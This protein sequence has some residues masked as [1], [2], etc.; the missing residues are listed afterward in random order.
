MS[1]EA[2]T[3]EVLLQFIFKLGL[4]FLKL[5]GAVVELALALEIPPLV[6][7]LDL[8]LV[9]CEEVDTVAFQTLSV[10]G[11]G[12]QVK[13]HHVLGCHELAQNLLAQVRQSPNHKVIGVEEQAEEESQ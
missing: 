4:N 8:C 13:V 2:D 7:F 9:N 5:A 3:D 1:L 12:N 6:A 10:V 11:M